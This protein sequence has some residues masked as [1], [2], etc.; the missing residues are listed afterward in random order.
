[1]RRIKSVVLIMAMLIVSLISSDRAYAAEP[2]RLVVNGRD[3]TH[4]SAPILDN[5]RTLVPV[6]F[7][8]EELGGRQG[9]L[10]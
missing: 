6:R 9:R 3:I 4:M 7:V 10:G 5:N 1:L 2:I 8:A